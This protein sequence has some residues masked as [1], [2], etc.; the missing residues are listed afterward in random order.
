MRHTLNRGKEETGEREREKR[1]FFI[2][3]A[4]S[5]SYEMSKADSAQDERERERERE[6]RAQVT[7]TVTQL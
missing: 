7:N 6:K 1:Y 2:D 4:S 3:P 5:F